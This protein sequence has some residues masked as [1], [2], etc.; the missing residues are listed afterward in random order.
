MVAGKE[1]HPKGRLLLRRMPQLDEVVFN[2]DFTFVSDG[3]VI[4]AVRLCRWLP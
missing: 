3:Y 2:V 4:V 1:I